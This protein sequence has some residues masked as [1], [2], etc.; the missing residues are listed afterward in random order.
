MSYTLHIGEKGEARVSGRRVNF[1][2][3]DYDDEIIEVT[4]PDGDTLSFEVNGV[5]GVLY[6]ANRM[7]RDYLSAHVDDTLDF[8]LPIPEQRMQEQ[9][10]RD[11]LSDLLEAAYRNERLPRP[12]PGMDQM[13]ALRR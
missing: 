4:S 13:A 7:T 3:E 10:R 8:H 11:V 2:F 5:R 6:G 12:P 9:P 1:F